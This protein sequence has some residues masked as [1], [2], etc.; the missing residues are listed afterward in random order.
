VVQLAYNA[1]VLLAGQEALEGPDGA[2][3][4]PDSAQR[5]V[6]AVK[7]VFRGAPAALIDFLLKEEPRPLC[8]E[9]Q[10]NWRTDQ[11]PPLSERPFLTDRMLHLFV[12]SLSSEMHWVCEGGRVCG[13]CRRSHRCRRRVGPHWKWR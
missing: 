10:V 1:V 6:D 2:L 4:M 3:P 13:R 11:P 5:D 12:S 8:L 7:K 9:F